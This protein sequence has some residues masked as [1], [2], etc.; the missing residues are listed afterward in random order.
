MSLVATE[1]KFG[2]LGAYRYSGGDPYIFTGLGL[3]PLMYQASGATPN[4]SYIGPLPIG[5]IRPM[6]FSTN[7]PAIFPWAMSWSPNIDW[8]FFADNAA[9]AVSR[10]IL[11]ATYNK[12]TASFSIDGFITLNYPNATLYTIREFG[13]TYDLHTSGQAA[14]GL[15]SNVVSG[16]FTNFSG[17]GVCVGNRIGF[18]S[19]SPTGI[20]SWYE[21]ASVINNTG[22]TLTTSVS[23]ASSGAFVIEDLRAI[24]L[25]TNATAANGGLYVVK[26]LRP[27]LFVAG[28]N[29]INTGVTTDNL[30]A[31]YWLQDAPVITN[32]A[33]VGFDL[34]P[35]VG[36][37]GQSLWAVDGTTTPKLFKYNI[38]KIPLQLTGSKD[39]SNFF[40]S[41]NTGGTL[42]GTA[43]QADNFVLANT[44][45]GPG[46]G[47]N[48]G[49]FTTTTKVYRTADVTTITSGSNVWL[50][51]N[52]TEIPAGGLSTFAASSLMNGIEYSSKIDKFIITVNATTTPFKSYIT[53]YQ[54]SSSQFDRNWG[55]DTRQI[56]QSAAD[57]TITPIVSMSSSAY[58]LVDNNGLIYIATIGTTAIGNRVYSVPL[59]ADW[60]YSDGSTSL[61]GPTNAFIITPAIPTPNCNNFV[62]LYVNEAKVLGGATTTNLGLPTEPYRVYYR[63][64]GITDDSG[65]WTLLADYHD[66]SS[67]IGTNQIQFKFEFRMIGTL[68]IPA[69]ILSV[70]VLYNDN[71]T[72]TQYQPSVANSNVST[73]TFAWRF[74]TAF[75]TTVPTLYVRLYDA[76]SNGLLVTDNTAAP[77][78]T[79]QKSTDGGNSW[80]AYDTNDLSSSTTTYIRYTPLS[81]GDNIKVLAILTLS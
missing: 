56:D 51:D 64:V 23:A 77:A 71:S 5:L 79:F 78:G 38:R 66:L 58:S 34:E 42:V 12:S 49:Y 40:F 55:V 53:Q 10:R 43:S 57:S 74:A 31:I 16:F 2:T 19:I 32:T 15:N 9:A 48:C 35:N 70:A 68:G 75:G 65:T 67:V 7:I 80:N 76:V 52:M 21:I 41:T 45:H 81:L 54:T 60:E 63:T 72:L 4:T 11:K 59:V 17:E 26:G 22:L 47:K 61:L 73:K 39:T 6:E 69:R 25:T 20:A 28:G 30:R 29:A 1:L 46:V 18:G 62:R 36:W 24:T 13:M 37:T 3:G 27:E 44:N 50:L 33:A 14:I 8:I